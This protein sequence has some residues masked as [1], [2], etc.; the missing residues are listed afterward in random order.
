[1]ILR[2]NKIYRQQENIGEEDLSTKQ[3]SQEKNSWFFGT[4][5]H[6][7]WAF[8]FKA[9]EGQRPEEIGG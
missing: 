9:Q 1:M 5:V 3:H 2:Q 7:R 4:Y 6:Q 8:S